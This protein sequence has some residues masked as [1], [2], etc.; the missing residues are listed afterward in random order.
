MTAV[1]LARARLGCLAEG[2]SGSLGLCGSAIVDLAVA[3]RS[4][5]IEMIAYDPVCPTLFEDRK[6]PT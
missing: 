2:A 4:S 3:S 5:P 6:A 1:I